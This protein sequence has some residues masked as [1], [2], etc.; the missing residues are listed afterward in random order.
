MDPYSYIVVLTSIV[1]GLGVT[2]LVGGLGHLLQRRKKARP[3]W[4]HTV[5]MINAL[6]VT[7]IVW[8]VSYRWRANQNWPFLLFLWM[9]VQP[10]LLYL[11][12]C[13]L[14]PDQEDREAVSDWRD[15]FFDN[16][17]RL[18]F[19]LAAC[20]PIDLF[21]TLL[22][23]VAHFRAQGPIYFGSM[24]FLMVLALTA[25]FTR[26]KWYQAFYAIFFLLY[27]M[28]LVGVTVLTDQ[29]MIGGTPPAP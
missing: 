11:I 28:A 25:A 12:A 16:R 22:K 14:F 2:R 8:Y 23:G 13:I 15:Y 19:L 9:L 18:F 26:Q 17:R 6:V 10:T 7:V 27:N 21:D 20:Y 24:I 1:M 29:G 3:Y 4:I 5:W